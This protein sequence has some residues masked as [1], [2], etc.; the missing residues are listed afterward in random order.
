MNM[1]I[2]YVIVRNKHFYSKAKEGLTDGTAKEMFLGGLLDL[3]EAI[4]GI[5]SP[6][7]IIAVPIAYTIIS[8]IMVVYEIIQANRSIKRGIE[9][10]EQMSDMES[11]ERYR[12]IYQ[13]RVDEGSYH[14]IYN[15]YF[16]VVLDAANTRIKNMKI[17]RQQVRDE[18]KT[19]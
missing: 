17:A 18:N 1:Y 6:V 19:F 14:E 10:L 16:R 15:H 5:L 12:D 8:P 9:Q 3:K 2:D 7:I 13:G 11:V 4:V